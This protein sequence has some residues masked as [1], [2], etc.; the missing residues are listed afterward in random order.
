MILHFSFVFHTHI[1]GFPFFL[2]VSS[3]TIS[4]SRGSNSS[5]FPII[6]NI[7]LCY[8]ATVGSNIK[9]KLKQ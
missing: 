3:H 1:L 2:I 7:F 6:H 4:Y 8:Y 5:A 9:L